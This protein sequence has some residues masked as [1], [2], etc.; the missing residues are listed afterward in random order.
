MYFYNLQFIAPSLIRCSSKIG[1][2]GG[3]QDISIGDGCDKKGVVIHEI[4]H[5]LG[6]WHE[7]SRPDRDDYII[8]NNDNIKQGTLL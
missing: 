8:I 6:R 1:R 7:H 3:Q 5:A 4:F 2:I